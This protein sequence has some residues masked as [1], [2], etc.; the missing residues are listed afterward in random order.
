[1]KSV[2]YSIKLKN[3][4][5]L[6]QKQES[7]KLYKE[8]FEK[9][10]FVDNLPISDSLKTVRICPSLEEK[11]RLSIVR[12]MKNEGLRQILSSFPSKKEML[13]MISWMMDHVAGSDWLWIQS[14]FSKKSR[15]KDL[16]G[17]GDLKERAILKS[18]IY[19]RGI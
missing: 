6:S 3:A 2:D 9:D 18:I 7:V 17:L 16:L 12:R 5:T 10:S 8:E 11:I 1:V 19:L 14:E 4:K 13:E 15:Q